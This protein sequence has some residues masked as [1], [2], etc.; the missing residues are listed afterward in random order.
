MSAAV[1]LWKRL[2]SVFRPNG[3]GGL[4]VPN[5]RA[6]RKQPEESTNAADAAP[7]LRVHRPAQS[8]GRWLDWIRRRGGRREQQERMLELLEEIH[9]RVGHTPRATDVQ[10]AVSRLNSEIGRLGA[11]QKSDSESLERMAANL[12][13]NTHDVER[14]SDTLAKLPETLQV[15]ADVLR[16]IQ[17]SLQDGAAHD[18]EV[19]ASIGRFEHSV[20]SLHQSAAA[21]VETLRKVLAA[22]ERERERLCGFIRTQR[23]RFM[24]LV[25]ALSV[26]GLGAAGL[27]AWMLLT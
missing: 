22:Q 21:Q 9:Q 19:R 26:L 15:Q 24:L 12:R 25:G 10:T 7:P 27:L 6:H 1:T 8:R 4:S 3:N 5:F 11:Q 16:A 13:S 14:M 17:E 23:R 20:S 2:E 18:E